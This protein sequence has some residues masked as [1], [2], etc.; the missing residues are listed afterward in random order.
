MPKQAFLEAGQIVGTHGVRGEVRV[1]P[2]CD[3][4]A[5]FATLTTLYWDKAGA[6]PVRVKSRPHKNIALAKLDGVDT[7]QDASALRGR[8]L[9]LARAD[10]K[11]PAGRYFI[12]DLIGMAIVDADMMMNAPRGLTAASGID[13]VPH[14]LEAY[15]S[16]MATDYT[17]GLALRSLKLIFENLPAAYEQGAKAPRARE[18]MAN[19]ATMAGY[20]LRQCLAGRMPLHG[21]QAGRFPPSAPR[22]CK[23]PAD[24][25]G[26]P[27]QCRQS[28]R[29]NG[30]L[31]PV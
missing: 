11:L 13:A 21:P 12:K 1:Q 30:H 27:L 10:L 29:E 4:P 22:H 6:S 5:L 3:S 17:D 18:N 2:W 20:G 19:A 8:L 7:V 15:A 28:F 25:P 31:L 26:P 14:A 16:I 24:P 23:C 9:Y